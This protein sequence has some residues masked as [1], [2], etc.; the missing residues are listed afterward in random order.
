MIKKIVLFIALLIAPAF[1]LAIC[2]PFVPNVVLTANALNSAIAG[3][4]ITSGTITGA[5]ISGVSLDGSAIGSIIPASAAFSYL[6]ANSLDTNGYSAEFSL[7]GNTTNP[8]IAFK[9]GRGTATAPTA[10]LAGDTLG[11]V[12]AFGYTGTGFGYGAS[13]DFLAAGNFSGTSFPTKIALNTTA[14]SATA[15]VNVLSVDNTGLTLPITGIL[16]A[17]TFSD[18]FTDG[19]VADYATGNGR[20]SVGSADTLTIYNGGIATTQL[21]QISSTGTTVLGLKYGTTGAGKLAASVTAPTI[22]SGFGSSPSV[23]QNNGTATFLINVGT[24]GTATSGVVTMPAATTG[25]SCIV[26]PTAAPQAAAIMYSQPTSTTSITITNYTLT[27]GVAL[28]WPA[29]TVI[30]VNCVGY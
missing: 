24:G 23:T 18:T 5:I 4:C 12:D 29:S 6:S 7:Y 8:G 9:D 26:S 28:A 20:I 21:E 16:A 15:P 30:A 11:N 3:P 19:L 2:N 17:G 22:A 25:W 13:I 14:T 10:S 27:T 1:A